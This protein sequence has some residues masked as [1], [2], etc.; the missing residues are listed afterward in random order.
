VLFGT[1]D[2]TPSSAASIV[3]NNALPNALAGV[4]VAASSSPVPF[5]GGVLQP[6][7]F[8]GPFFANTGAGGSITINF[9]VPASLPS[10]A[11]IWLQ[12]AIKDVGA[13]QGVALSNAIKG[14]VP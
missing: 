7:P 3:L 5:K 14:V 8:L 13:V 2:L 9:T 4:F 6:N 11:Q 12:W 10:G 1:G